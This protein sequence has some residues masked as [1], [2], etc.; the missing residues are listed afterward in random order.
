[1][2]QNVTQFI[3]IGALVFVSLLFIISIGFYFEKTPVIEKSLQP[4][5]DAGLQSMDMRPVGECYKDP[6]CYFYIFGVLLNQPADQ[7]IYD[8]PG[9]PESPL[10]A[11]FV[12]QTTWQAQGSN[13]PVVKR[14]VHIINAQT[15]LQCVRDKECAWYAFSNLISRSAMGDQADKLL[16]KWE[17]PIYYATEPE[18]H[19]KYYAEV[20]NAFDQVLPYVSVSLQKDL[21]FNV[22]MFF[23]FDFKRDVLHTYKNSFYER[24]GN[25]DAI[26][27]TFRKSSNS[28]EPQTCS[29]LVFTGNKK[30]EIRGAVSFVHIDNRYR[31]NCIYQSVYA[32]LG[33]SSVLKGFPFSIVTQV[34]D[35][36]HIPPTFT[37]LDLFM[38]TLL[39]QPDFKNGMSVEPEKLRPVF[40]AAYPAALE[41]FNKIYTAK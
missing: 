21:S 27:E 11:S 37:N 28:N 8:Q 10:H 17:G 9:D 5:G 36:L 14:P 31:S 38:I 13:A 24:F 35:E 20:K 29:N 15:P 1:M 2:K 33:F 7:V 40:D 12:T 23:S 34:N 26:I 3:K 30:H 19:E 6:A 41:K 39:Y 32:V 25:T 16:N 22:L 4:M 18:P